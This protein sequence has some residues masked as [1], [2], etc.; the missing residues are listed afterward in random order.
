MNTFTF[1]GYPISKILNSTDENKFTRF[2]KGCIGI[3]I[4]PVIEKPSIKFY[5]KH[6]TLFETVH[7]N[8]SGVE[9]RRYNGEEIVFFDS[10][11][12]KG[13]FV[14]NADALLTITINRTT[15]KNLA[16]TLG[17]IAVFMT[18][19]FDFCK[20]PTIKSMRNQIAKMF[21]EKWWLVVGLEEN[22]I[23]NVKREIE[24]GE[25]DV[26]M[27]ALRFSDSVE[28][29]YPESEKCIIKGDVLIGEK[30]GQPIC[31]A[32]FVAEMVVPDFNIKTSDPRLYTLLNPKRQLIKAIQY[33][34]NVMGKIK[35]NIRLNQFTS[36]F[37]TQLIKF[38]PFS[39]Q[40]K[41]SEFIK[42]LLHTKVITPG[43][44]DLFIAV[45]Y[46][47]AYGDKQKNSVV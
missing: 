6:S 40:E 2:V 13:F 38:V 27:G 23:R 29:E 10:S 15:L 25:G 24:N 21:T 11:T 20:A 19:G 44:N 4:I 47:F 7:T 22:S 30:T 45:F 33:N 34:L 32:P 43:Q 46:N 16:F 36:P 1:H 39:L 12:S 26:V 42:G 37:Y 31:I 41:T 18:K 17:Q 5:P 3:E 14:H 35:A 28:I 8:K 9:F